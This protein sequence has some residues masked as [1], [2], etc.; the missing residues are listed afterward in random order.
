MNMNHFKGENKLE[1]KY[2]ILKS[3]KMAEESFEIWKDYRIESSKKILEE[4]KDENETLVIFGA[5][6]CNDIDLGSFEKKF[7]KITLID[8]DKSALNNAI[9][10]HGLEDSKKIVL[11]EADFLGVT[12][13]IYREYEDMLRGKESVKKINKFVRNIANKIENTPIEIMID[14]HE[15]GICMGV[16]SQLSVVF[17][18]LLLIYFKNFSKKEYKRI[19]T[20]LEYM[21]SK[22]AQRLNNLILDSITN[23]AFFGFDMM[24]LSKQLGTDKYFYEII[25]YAKKKDF[26]GLHN[27]IVNNYLISGASDGQRD[28]INRL[29]KDE[30]KFECFN[31]LFW[32]FDQNRFYL[33]YLYTLLKE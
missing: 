27:N 23:K 29:E 32:P 16:H 13:D 22:I 10:K 2:E 12:D 21:N 18:G 4:I 6:E 3:T 11:I 17:E 14:R 25:D 30:I 1:Y 20:E 33:V 24:E 31:T 15:V 19:H 26:V 8:V 5:G 7:N 9:I 28:I